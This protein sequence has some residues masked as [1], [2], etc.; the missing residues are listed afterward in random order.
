MEERVAIP[1]QD[2][3]LEGRFSP[4]AAGP[5]V[6]ITHPHPLFGGSLDNNVVWTAACA[7]Q[8]RGWATLR[9]NFRG[10]G[11]STGTYAEGE[12]EVADVAAALAFLT[13]RLPGPYYVAGYSFGA[14]VVARALCQGLGAD[15]ALLIAP[16]VAFMDLSF[17]PAVPRLELIVAGD[18]DQL[19]PLAMLQAM[20]KERP[21]P[22][23]I[24]VIAGAD[25][26]FG[27]WEAELFQVLREQPWSGP[28]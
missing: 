22:L 20:L 5:G 11:T 10:V 2:L 28:K 1:A 21:A 9:F 8:T 7:F 14:Y 17:L 26:F 25:H 12:G 3:T 16:P 15:G 6:I 27:G 19:C 23:K 13:T 18:R 24:A 4:G